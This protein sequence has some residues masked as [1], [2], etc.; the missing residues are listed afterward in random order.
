MKR[1]ARAVAMILRR[2][3][4]ADLGIGKDRDQVFQPVGMHYVIR[5]ENADDFC[6]GRGV[7]ERKPER[8]GLEALE[9]VL[10]HELEALAERLA[11]LFDRP[12]Q[13]R[14]GSVVDDKDALKVRILELSH[15]VER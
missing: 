7:F 12:P 14:I 5:V 11:M 3:D 4:Q 9:A 6:V 13:R 10:A 2:L 15:R 8:A 1:T